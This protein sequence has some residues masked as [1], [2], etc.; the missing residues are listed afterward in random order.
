MSRDRLFYDRFQYCL[1]F[2]LPELASMRDSFEPQA[3]TSQLDFRARWLE[4]SK[5]INYG[6]SW[7]PR[8]TTVIT[9]ET[10]DNCLAFAVLMTRYPDS[11]L[12]IFADQGY[13]YTNDSELIETVS[14]TWYLT[15]LTYR[16]AELD[17]PRDTL[18]IRNAQHE[19]R[20]YFRQKKIKPEARDHIKRFLENQTGIRV[21]TGL[22]NWLNK[23]SPHVWLQDNF[24]IDHN[25]MSFLTLLALV[26]PVPIRKTVQLIKE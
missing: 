3:V 22:Q 2:K 26:N 19:Y 17:R 24:F 1:G 25:D 6:G 20:S 7:R 18:R 8:T 14:D 5:H 4:Q 9:A 21:S 12:V 10:R 23:P 11:K 15:N 16:Q 13:L